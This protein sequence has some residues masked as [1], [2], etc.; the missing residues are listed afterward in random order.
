MVDQNDVAGAPAPDGDAASTKRGIAAMTGRNWPK[1]KTTTAAGLL[2]AACIGALAGG[3]TVALM[4]AAQGGGA[5]I[6]QAEWSRLS[7]RV[8]TGATEATR[9]ATD[10][11]L[12]R[13]R[14]IQAQDAADKG[15]AET[16]AR[17]GQVS[18]RLERLHRQEADL[19]AKVAAVAE[20]LA[21]MAERQEH[22]DREQAARFSALTDKLDK[23][24]APVAAAPAAALPVASAP[25]A[26][27]PVAV[28]KPVAATEPALTGS[29]PDKPADKAKPG[30]IEGWVLRDV[31]DG[32]AMIENRN[33]RL[34]EIGP[35]DTLPG[36]GR[37]EAIE[38]RG[39]T[40][41]VVTSKGLITATQSW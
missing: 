25:V 7:G 19:A 22:A 8:E 30:T 27:A 20:R 14:T 9:L 32:M 4:N 38:R 23:R 16:G 21:A 28:H 24:P 39:R 36:A 35:G 29:L 17:L 40:W 10:L 31:Y 1:L 33:R 6:P 13:D 26:P 18:E 11:S 3:A 37:V 12:L 15:R 5:G 41:V 34:L 2:C